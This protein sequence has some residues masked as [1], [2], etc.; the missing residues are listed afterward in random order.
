MIVP[1][2][3]YTEFV[4]QKKA[5]FA[6]GTLLSEQKTKGAK[7]NFYSLLLIDTTFLCELG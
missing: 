2:V 7:Y 6:T 4:M 3:L 5:D 1:E